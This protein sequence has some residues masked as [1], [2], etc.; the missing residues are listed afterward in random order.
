[1]WHRKG[2]RLL[3]DY[4][5][6]TVQSIGN[7]DKGTTHSYM[8]LYDEWL[9]KYEYTTANIVEIGVNQGYSIVMLASY[10]KNASI[11]GIELFPNHITK[12]FQDNV[13]IIEGDATL[14]ETANKVPENVD[15]LID[16]GS[17]RVI[18]Q[19]TSFKLF[20][21][22]INAGGIYIIEDIDDLKSFTNAITTDPFFKNVDYEILDL[23]YIKE[24]YDDVL[25]IARK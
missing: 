1:V 15:V 22:K 9:A 14:L 25:F 13:T 6:P 2:N 7:A 16:D 24:R 10:F 5:T 19:I 11:L 17:H 12:D 21:N 3:S 18:D 23:R 20:W 8:D 4:Y